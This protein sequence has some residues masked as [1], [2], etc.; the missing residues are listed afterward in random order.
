MTFRTRD[1][2]FLLIL[3]VSFFCIASCTIESPGISVK[4][5]REPAVVIEAAEKQQQEM[6]QAI[7]QMNQVT[8]NNVFTEKDGVPEYIVGPGDVLSIIYWTPFA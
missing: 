5:Y 6:T 2:L 1:V 4:T 8:E 3:I 7:Q